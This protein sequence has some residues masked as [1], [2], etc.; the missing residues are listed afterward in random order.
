MR[1][2]VPYKTK[3]SNDDDAAFKKNL[4]NYRALQTFDSI[5]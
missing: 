4:R 1:Q 2:I 3:V 5:D